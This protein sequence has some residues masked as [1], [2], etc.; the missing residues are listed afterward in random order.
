MKEKA[1]ASLK[2][3]SLLIS[4]F[5][6]GSITGIGIDGVYR[7]KT[8]ASLREGRRADREAM[9]DKIRRDLNLTDDQ[10]KEMHRVL[11]ETADEFRALRTEL[12]PR[13]EAL[14]LKTRGQMR[15]LLTP[16]QQQNFDALM[17][18]IDARRQKGEG[19]AR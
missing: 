1:K 4:V 2:T 10:S 13:Y 6:L 14:R 12:K 19:D 17:A 9:F 18:E 11:D 7:A 16:E 5:A 15:A 8:N 3:W